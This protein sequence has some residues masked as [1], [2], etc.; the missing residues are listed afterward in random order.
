[1][2]EAWND[3]LRALQ[4]TTLGVI[5]ELATEVQDPEV[6]TPLVSLR[7]FFYSLLILLSPNVHITQRS[8]FCF[9]L[10]N[11]MLCLLVEVLLFA[12]KFLF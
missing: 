10:C 7:I 6:R 8:I 3:K 1:M 2:W 4:H 9:D 12:A 11:Q 5:S